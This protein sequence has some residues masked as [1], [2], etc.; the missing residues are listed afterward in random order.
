MIAMPLRSLLRIAPTTVAAVAL[1]LTQALAPAARAAPIGGTVHGDAGQPIEGALVRVSPASSPDSFE[2]DFDGWEFR[3]DIETLAEV[4]RSTE[5]ALD[6]ETS[7]R[8][9]TTGR[10]DDGT[11]WLQKRFFL[12]P[13]TTYQVYLSWYQTNLFTDEIGNWPVLAF[14]GT[15]APEQET[16]FTLVGFDGAAEDFTRYELDQQVTTDSSGQIVLAFGVS[17]VFEVDRVHFFDV[18]RPSIVEVGDVVETTTDADGTF[19]LELAP[20]AYRVGAEAQGFLPDVDLPVEPGQDDTAF[21]LIK[22]EPVSADDLRYMVVESD[23]GG[24]KLFFSVSLTT[25]SGVVLDG[26]QCLGDLDFEATFFGILDSVSTDGTCFFEYTPEDGVV[27]RGSAFFELLGVEAEGKTYALG[28]FDVH[29]VK[30]VVP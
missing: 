15:S 13:S 26:A 21:E 23:G 30:F 4:E 18:V 25:P 5:V 20:G 17:V 12:A 1:L 8:F 9:S 7:V 16:D 29:L 27:P 3:Q 2:Q 19:S 24:E 22:I 11:A 6:G 14:A 28:R 10:F